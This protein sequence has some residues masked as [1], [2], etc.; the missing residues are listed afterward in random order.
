MPAAAFWVRFVLWTYPPLG[1]L[2][3]GSRS[4]MADELTSRKR[5]RFVYRSA[6]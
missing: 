6:T 1:Q 2:T 5:N 3:A 4:V